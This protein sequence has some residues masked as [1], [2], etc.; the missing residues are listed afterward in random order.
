MAI[1]ADLV[2]FESEGG[3]GVP[4]IDIND[5]GSIVA[6]SLR[7]GDLVI[8]STSI[9][10]QG[11]N[12]SITLTP[13]GT[14]TVSMPK[15]TV[16]S[17]T[18]DHVVFSN[19]GAL[20]GSSAL[21][22]NGTVLGVVGTV[23]AR[24]VV[25]TDPLNELTLS[26][27]TQVSIT[28]SLSVTGNASANNLSATVK[29]SA[30][31]VEAVGVGSKIR[32]YFNDVASFPN[33]ATWEG[34]LAYA[35]DVKRVYISIGSEWREMV[36]Y[37]PPAESPTVLQIDVESSGTSTFANALISGG[38][39]NGTQIGNVTPSTAAF[40]TATATNTPVLGIELT[41]KSYVDR[42]TNL[43]IALSG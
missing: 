29:A 30:P 19:N 23:N 33:A 38:A 42:R 10:A 22:W 28:A 13:T 11:A 15:L 4:G 18:D 3:F 7:G 14:G 40:T 16:T 39:I 32:F 17:I 34:S 20:V 43:A 5:D 9:T 2:K 25:S 24:S 31:T 21:T 8:A 26:S 27:P 41:N 1:N 37:T 35:H 6:V 36:L 12:K